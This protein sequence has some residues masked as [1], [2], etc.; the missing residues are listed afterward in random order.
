MIFAVIAAICMLVSLGLYFIS[1]NFDFESGGRSILEGS[2]LFFVVGI[3]LL[4]VSTGT[5]VGTVIS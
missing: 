1:G 3:F 4:G 2:I 5:V